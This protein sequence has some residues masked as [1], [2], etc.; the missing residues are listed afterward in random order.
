M[1]CSPCYHNI[2]YCKKIMHSLLLLPR[3]KL[4]NKK[5][6]GL[7]YVF[8]ACASYLPWQAAYRRNGM[9]FISRVIHVTFPPDGAGTIQNMHAQNL[10][11]TVW[12]QAEDHPDLSA[13]NFRRPRDHQPC[14]PRTLRRTIRPTL[15]RIA[16]NRMYS[17]SHAASISTTDRQ[18]TTGSS[19][20]LGSSIR[21]RTSSSSTTTTHGWSTTEPSPSIPNTST[22]CSETTGRRVISSIPFSRWIYC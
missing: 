20:R 6:A 11:H 4:L 19:M 17:S 5:G 15:E 7:I 14:R 2:Q 8:L 21:P 12:D 3:S 13:S 1:R 10:F 9:A 18:P 16:P 22:R